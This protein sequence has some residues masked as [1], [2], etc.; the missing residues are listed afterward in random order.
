MPK[1][2]GRRGF[3]HFRVALGDA[4]IYAALFALGCDTASISRLMRV[5]E[6]TV[7]NALVRP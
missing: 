1:T 3:R 4:A 6:A 2:D 5:S 7:Y